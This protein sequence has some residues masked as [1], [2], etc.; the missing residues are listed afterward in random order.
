[1]KIMNPWEFIA[2]DII[3]NG[4]FKNTKEFDK[5]FGLNERLNK[6]VWLSTPTFEERFCRRSISNRKERG[7]AEYGAKNWLK[8]RHS[9]ST[10]QLDSIF[11]EFWDGDVSVPSQT[12]FT[13]VTI[14]YLVKQ[15]SILELRKELE[16]LMK[17]YDVK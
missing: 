13:V 5:I 10:E 2:Q 1:M 4:R 7:A 9:F 15:Q 14:S 11:D 6:A 17:E 3:K 8:R 16:V 12:F